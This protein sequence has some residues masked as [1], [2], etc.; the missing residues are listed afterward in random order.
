[1]CVWCVC[2]IRNSRLCGGLQ[3]YMEQK[4]AI[5]PWQMNEHEPSVS[6]HCT[7][8]GRKEERKMENLRDRANSR[9]EHLLNRNRRLC[10]CVTLSLWKRDREI[11]LLARKFSIILATGNSWPSKMKREHDVGIRKKTCRKNDAQIRVCIFDGIAG[12]AVRC[13]KREAH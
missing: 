5:E 10:V 9:Q 11:W 8:K 2:M 3:S 12:C 13:S 4:E 7:N 1:M 6:Q